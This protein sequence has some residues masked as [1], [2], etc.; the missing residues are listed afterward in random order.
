MGGGRYHMRPAEN[1]E[2]P[3]DPGKDNSGAGG[4]PKGVGVLNSAPKGPRH[5]MDDY[6]FGLQVHGTISDAMLF[7][8]GYIAPDRA[9]AQAY[10]LG[11]LFGNEQEGRSEVVMTEVRDTVLAIIPD[12]LRIFTQTTTI[13]QFIPSNSKTVEQADQATD[14]VNHIFWNDNAGFEIFHNCLKDALTVKTGVIKWHWSDDIEVTEADYSGISH[15]QLLLLQ[16]E[17]DLEIIEAEPVT[18]TE[19]VSMNG[20]VIVPAEVVYDVRIRR[21]RKKQRVVLECIPPEEFLI[22]RETRDL[23]TSRYIGHRSLKTV[24]Q[25]IDMGYDADEVENISNSDDSY[26]LTN[27]EAIT[28]NPAINIFSRDTG[29]NSALK[30]F[31]Y[32]ESWIRIDRDG[33]GIAEL[34]KVCSIGPHILFDEVADEVPF[35]VFCPDP[36]PHLLIGQSVADQTMDLQLIKSAVVRDTLDSLKQSINPR[37]V[38]VEGQVNLDDVMNNE[39]GNIIRARQPGMVQSLDTPFQGQYALPVI[40]YLDQV[41]ENRTGINAGANGLD[42]DALQSTTPTAVNAAVQAG[43]ARKEMIARLFADNGMKRLMKGI[44]RMVVRHQDK[45]RMIRLRDKFVEMDPRFW[46]SDLDCVPNVALG[47]GTDQQSLAFLAQVAGKQEQIIQLLGPDNPLAPVDKYRETLAEMCHL[48]GFKD[49]T[50]FF[51]DVTPQQL[52]QHAQQQPQKQDPTMMLAQIEQQK[53]QVQA[54]KNQAEAQQKN[55]QM[56][57]D[58]QQAAMKMRLDYASKLAVAQIAAT[59]SF[60]EAQLEAFISR[61]EAITTAQMQGMVDHHANLMQSAVDHHGNAMDAQAQ[62]ES[63]RLAAQAQ[64]ETVQ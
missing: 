15:D 16:R 47:R 42:A 62:V 2:L 20:N 53:V 33:D 58:H 37:T 44:Y 31:V 39:I 50:K 48:A 61:D 6:E 43:Q 28:R 18:K 4:K 17:E 10:Y 26:Y 38:V 56:M 24:S 32:V 5:L 35:A 55:Q 54:Q 41:K 46:D 25:L 21:K 36:T 64:P 1:L 13:V 49:E 9:L 57:L 34:R 8:D 30:R 60:N 52:Q 3:G 51:G 45:P 12:L 23:D 40:Q 7:I 19:A 63:A 27:L 14:Y 59:G 29:P 11:R 22:D